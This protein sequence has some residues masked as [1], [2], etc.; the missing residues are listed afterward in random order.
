MRSSR[1]EN[2]L[3]GGVGIYV[4]KDISSKL[5]SEYTK[6]NH[7]VIWAM[8]QF[9]CLSRRLLCLIFASVYYP[10]NAQNRRDLVFFFFFSQ[11][12]A[13]LIRSRYSCPGF[14]V[15]GDFNQTKRNWLVTSLSLKQIVNVPT[16]SPGSIMDLVLT[17]IEGFYHPL[18]PLGRLRCL[19]TTF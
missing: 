9:P 12:T 6:P 3:N 1:S 15:T 11:T 18:F 16:H 2:R 8:C 10:E 17:N 19:I 4:R 13:D 7:E 14:T 5:L